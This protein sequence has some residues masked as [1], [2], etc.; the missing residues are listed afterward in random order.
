MRLGGL[1]LRRRQLPD[2]WPLRGLCER[3]LLGGW[4]DELHGLDELRGGQVRLDGRD[5]HQR[6]ELHGL[7]GGSDHDE[8]GPELLLDLHGRDLPGQ[9]RS[10]DLRGLRCGELLG[11]GGLELHDLRRGH[12]QPD[13]G[14]DELRV[15]EQLRSRDVCVHG[16]HEHQRPRL[17]DLRSGGLLD[18]LERD[19]LL[20]LDQLQRGHLHLDG[21][22]HL[23]RSGVFDLRRGDLHLER[24]PDE[25]RVL[26]ELLGRELRVD[27][28]DEHERPRLYDLRL[29]LHHHGECRELH[30]LGDLRG[31]DVHLD[32]G[33][34]HERSG[35]H[36]LR[37]RHL[38]LELQRDGL[39]G[40]HGRHELREQHGGDGLHG[41][42]DLQLGGEGGREDGLH[43][44][45]EHGLH[46]GP[47]PRLHDGLGLREQL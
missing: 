29:G 37:G 25:L 46:R 41:L 6:S 13:D 42:L 16:R 44:D 22:D 47:G 10:D 33:D 12:V 30:G 15:L 11:L 19:G 26:G 40:L 23:K 36:E 35:L 3:E 8:R 45:G 43:G 21:G 32:G 2:E 4:S 38:L 9:R 5:E 34:E 28:R 24:G 39:C 20:A 18:Q 31:R 1:L 7:P 27:G 17:H 14:A